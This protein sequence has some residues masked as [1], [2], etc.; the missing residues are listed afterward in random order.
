MTKQEILD[1][2][3]EL[4]DFVN[5]NGKGR[6]ER[7]KEGIFVLLEP[8]PPKVEVK[9]EPEPVPAPEPTPEPEPEVEPE[10]PAKE[11]VHAKPEKTVVH[12][13]KVVVAKH[14][15]HRR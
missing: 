12:K 4:K 13:H 9:P 5:E 2:L 1:R 6:I 3:E 14:K 11:E 7:I 8:E 15:T 10:P